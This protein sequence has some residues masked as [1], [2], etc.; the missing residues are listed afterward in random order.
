MAPENRKPMSTKANDGGPFFPVALKSPDGHQCGGAGELWQHCGASQRTVIA[1]LAMQGLIIAAI[2][3][4]PPLS[5][6][7]FKRTAIPASVEYADLLL[8][9]L[10]KE[11]P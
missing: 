1:A 3:R 10:N 5:F 8:A 7:E 4:A 11:T 2:H 6:D 9:E